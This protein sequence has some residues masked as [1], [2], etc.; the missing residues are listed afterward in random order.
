MKPEIN[1][2]LTNRDVIAI[3]QDPLGHQARHIYSKGEVEVWA[4][5]LKG[6]AKAI[7][8][9]NVGSDVY[10]THPFHL[11]LAPLG[12]HGPQHA[13]DLWSGKEMDLTNNMPIELPSHDVLLLKVASPAGR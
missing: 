2:I 8:I 4:R 9:V 11:D 13:K 7:A 10:S 1:Q 5:D 6:G 3:N 12:L